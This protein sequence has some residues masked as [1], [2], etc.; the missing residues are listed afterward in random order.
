MIEKLK[1]EKLLNNTHNLNEEQRAAITCLNNCVVKAGAGAGKTTVLSYRFLNILLENKANCDEILTLTF[2]KKAA[3]EMYERIYKQ[4]LQIKDKSLIIEKQLSLFNKATI[5][6]IDSFC[7]QI[8]KQDCIRYGIPSDFIIDNVKSA[9]ITK[10]C[11]R[12]LIEEEHIHRGFEFLSKAYSPDDLI[13]N[14]LVKLASSSF[15]FPLE[16]DKQILFQNYEVIIKES[17]TDLIDSFFSLLNGLCEVDNDDFSPSFKKSLSDI[18]DF[19]ERVE[20][21][22]IDSDEFLRELEYFSFTTPRKSKKVPITEE[23]VEDCKSL[24]DVVLNL[25]IILFAKKNDYL[26]D[27]VDA[28]EILKNKIFKEKRRQGILT[29]SDISHLAVDILTTNKKLRNIYKEKF[30]YIMVDEFQDNNQLQK[31]LTYL[32]SEKKSLSIDGIPS[33]NS[34]DSNK[35]FFVGD[36]KQSIYKFRDADVSVFKA[37]SYEIENSGGTLINLKTNYRSEPK[38]IKYFNSAFEKVFADANKSFEANF[39][40]LGY[41][42]ASENID[43]KIELYIKTEESDSLVG[44][45][46]EAASSS[47]SE[48]TKIAKIINNMLSSDDYLIPDKNGGVKRPSVNDIAILL[49]SK[50]HQ[51][52]FEK[53]LRAKN[54][55]FIIQD[56]KAYPLEALTNDIYNILQLLI[57]PNDKLAYVSVLKG[58]F[59]SISEKSIITIIE[60]Y[61]DENLFD[62]TLLEDGC[63]KQKLISLEKTFNELIELSKNSDISSLFNYLWWEVGL[64]YYYIC[65]PNYHVYLDNFDYLYRLAKRYDSN[66]YSLSLFID[67]MRDSLGSSSKEEE[68]NV[69]KERAL[70]VQIMTIHKSKGLEFPIVIVANMGTSIRPKA[71]NYSIEYNIPIPKHCKIID[72]RYKNEKYGSLFVERANEIRKEK[73]IA[74]IK[75][76]LYVALTRSETHLIMSATIRSTIENEILDKS[77]KSLLSMIYNASIMDDDHINPLIKIYDIEEVSSYENYVKVEKKTIIERREYLNNIKY[78]NVLKKEYDTKLKNIGVTKYFEKEHNFEMDYN[79]QSTDTKVDI[80]LKELSEANENVFADF[81]TLC[82]IYVQSLIMKNIILPLTDESVLSKGSSLSKLKKAQIKEIENQALIYAKSFVSSNFY[83]KYV[84]NNINSC[85]V[86]FFYR[87]EDENGEIRVLEGFIDL[88]VKDEEGNYLIVDFKTDKQIVPKIHENQINTYKKAVKKLYPNSSVKGCVAYL[89][90]IDNEYFY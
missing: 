42:A 45:S 52:E 37:L 66:Q 78:Y 60:N 24:K 16:F 5:S 48:A 89:R 10:R 20:T 32:L 70:G 75:R 29:F 14:V 23:I 51:I 53:A 65:E 76:I 35:L 11:V 22:D 64:R 19:R 90:Y 83:N 2:T 26:E 80:L 34:I 49:R 73:E 40:P 21:L 7:N 39:E 43:P 87:I 44:N 33:I 67:E 58:P 74:E 77:E 41:R 4:L 88:L 84:K 63:D 31:D 62:S 81:G 28:L 57:Y 68:V 18:R 86:G 59:G 85:E 3:A 17:L 54:I 47:E 82:H 30:K 71:L 36:E 8:V 69:L 15:Y 12:E 9:E 61:D 27:V 1:V 13:D 50:T 46:L 56:N 38:L 72:K 6:T 79:I 25:Y 55:P